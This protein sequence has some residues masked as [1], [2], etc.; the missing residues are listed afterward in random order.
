MVAKFLLGGGCQYDDIVNDIT[1]GG[2][3]AGLKVGLECQL[4]GT[5]LEGNQGAPLEVQQGKG[6]L[7]A[8]SMVRSCFSS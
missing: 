8:G 5:P 7:V 3:G 2:F 1:N 6:G 4:Q